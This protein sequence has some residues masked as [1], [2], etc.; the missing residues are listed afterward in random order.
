MARSFLKIDPLCLEKISDRGNTPIHFSS[1]SSNGKGHYLPN[2][3]SILNQF[4]LDA[5]ASAER[6]RIPHGNVASPHGIAFK[7]TKEVTARDQNSL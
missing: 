2:V 7:T 5:D 6:Y 1:S 4:T 3:D